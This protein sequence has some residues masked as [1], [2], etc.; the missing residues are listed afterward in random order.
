MNLFKSNLYKIRH[1][2]LLFGILIMSIGYAA[3]FIFKIKTQPTAQDFWFKTSVV[4]LNCLEP[5]FLS[6]IAAVQ[7]KFEDKASNLNRIL[8]F[9]R[10]TSWLLSWAGQTYL[11]WLLNLFVIN[12]LF[13]VFT[14]LSG[15]YYVCFWLSLAILGIIWIP[16]IE[17][18]SILHGYMAGLVT[19]FISIPFT[20]YYG[21]SQ[22]GAST[23]RLLPWVYHVKIYL[24]PT[25]QLVNFLLIVV[26]ITLLEQI[27]VNWR[28]NHW[29]GN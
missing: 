21:T 4:Y 12:L 14:H 2:P 1:Q 20:V 7:R 27:L 15:K 10:R 17:F 22:L 6:L 19:G 8:S 25:T 23:W 29:V 9:P 28:F 16:I 5:F 18:F 26:I 11:L 24:I 3:Y 13:L